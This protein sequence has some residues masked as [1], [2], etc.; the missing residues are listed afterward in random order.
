MNNE[1]EISL[2]EKQ[3]DIVEWALYKAPVGV[4]KYLGVLGGRGGGKSTIEAILLMT[5]VNELPRS[6]G[7]LP[8]TNVTK[9]KRAVMP[10]LKANLRDLYGIVPYN[11]KSKKG[12][13]V[14]WREPPDDWDRPYQEPDDWENCISFPNGV[15]AEVCGYQMDPDAHRGRNDDWA[16]LDEALKFKEEWLSVLFPCIRANV[17]K[18]DSP[19]HWLTA[20]FT[21]PPYGTEASWLYSFEKNYL[22]GDPAYFF[23]FIKTADNQVFLPPD[24]IAGLRKTL[25]KIQFKVEVLGERIVRPE[26]VYY[27]TFSRDIHAP[28]PSDGMPLYSPNLPLVAS[29]DFNAHF[30]SA[31]LYQNPETIYHD[32][33]R[34]VFVKEPD[35][36]INI[37]QTLARKMGEDLR[38]HQDKRIILTGDRNGAN[39]SAQAR[40]VDGRFLTPFDE[41]AE[42]LTALGWS[43]IIQP[44]LVNPVGFDR[45]QM[46][47]DVFSEKENTFMILRFDPVD[48]MPVVLSIENSPI[49]PDYSKNK[50]SETDGSDQELATHLSDSNDYYCEFVRQG[51]GSFFGLSGF[52]FDIL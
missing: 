9:F 6:K 52:D 49:N 8:F 26:K 46:M 31:N 14:L 38:D 30:T 41:M 35:E 12:D 39:K 2:N 47:S 45:Y 23:Q 50:K 29:V 4:K 42:E 10:G 25:L 27:P 40:F 3:A 28:E 7:Q 33:V 17:G 22:Q 21:T 13:Y 43:V 48:A 44:I 18:Y 15:V 11:F 32:C 51:G 37:T 19:I 5:I 34:S 16:L 24:Y 20:Y 1:I 36:G